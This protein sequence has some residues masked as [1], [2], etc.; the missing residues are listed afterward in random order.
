MLG[1]R[2]IELLR[3]A[4]HADPFSVLGPHDDGQGGWTVCVFLPGAA[5]VTLLDAAG[6]A[7]LLELACCHP[8][9]V[10]EGAGT[11]A[12]TSD[13]RLRVRWS[14]GSESVLDDPYLCSAEM[15][16]GAFPG[17]LRT[18]SALLPPCAIRCLT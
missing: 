4:A 14:G 6:V 7:P 11:G 5:A 18:R 1:E 8:D 15:S 10:F 16:S 9:G 2:D 12:R 17:S 3:A 13:Y